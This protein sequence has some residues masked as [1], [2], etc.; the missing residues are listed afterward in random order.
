MRTIGL[1][2]PAELSRDALR[3]ALILAGWL[4]ERVL[5]VSSDGLANGIRDLP[6]GGLVV[7]LEPCR[8]PSMPSHMTSAGIECHIGDLV[9]TGLSGAGWI[10]RAV[11]AITLEAGDGK[12]A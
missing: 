5:V 6:R 9:V 4:P 11:D 8:N 7:H 10:A 2:G 1:S 12:S 3:E